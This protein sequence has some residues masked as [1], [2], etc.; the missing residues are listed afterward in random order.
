M[1]KEKEKLT[2]KKKKRRSYIVG[3]HF[4]LYLALYRQELGSN[5]DFGS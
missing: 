4:V 1:T 2:R 3:E 5:G